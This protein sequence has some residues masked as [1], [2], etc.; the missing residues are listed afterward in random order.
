MPYSSKI[1][2]SSA[3]FSNF[4]E[5]KIIPP[6]EKFFTLRRIVATEGRKE[7]SA[8]DFHRARQIFSQPHWSHLEQKRNRRR[9][10]TELG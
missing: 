6:A 3:D 10:S 4:F 1:C 7:K 8:E 5:R 2:S 9:I